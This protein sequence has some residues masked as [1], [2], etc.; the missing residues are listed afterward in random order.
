MVEGLRVRVEGGLRGGEKGGVEGLGGL[1]FETKG[2]VF[3]V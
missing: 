1:G 2:L 3:S